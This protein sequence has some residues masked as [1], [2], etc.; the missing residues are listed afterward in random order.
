[1]LS[2]KKIYRIVYIKSYI[3]I[4]INKIM[5]KKYKLASLFQKLLFLLADYYFFSL[6]LLLFGIAVFS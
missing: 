3:S 2:I 5:K 6:L 4:Y 1:M